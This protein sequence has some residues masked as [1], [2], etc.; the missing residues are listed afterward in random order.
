MQVRTI[1]GHHTCTGSCIC[2]KR[3]SDPGRG[4]AVVNPECPVK[5]DIAV[6]CVAFSPDA[7]RVVSCGNNCPVVPAGNNWKH[8]HDGLVMMWNVETGAQ[9]SAPPR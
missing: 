2:T 6:S 4:T 1:G 7:Q 8:A 3:E 5:G 9:V